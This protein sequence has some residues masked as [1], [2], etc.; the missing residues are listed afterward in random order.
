MTI[1]VLRHCES[2]FNVDPASTQRDCPL[3][4]AGELHAATLRGHYELV[5]V[6]PLR[7]ARQTLELSDITYGAVETCA[8]AREHKT[9]P[10]DC[11]DGEAFGNESEPEV[12]A[13]AARLKLFLAEAVARHGNVL[14]IAHADIVWYLTASRE[15]DGDTYGVWLDP[16]E[17]RRLDP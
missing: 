11:V 2:V 1:T 9:G 6:S 7:R 13:R 10:C 3:S 15:G 16:G 12:I 17:M 14:L 4:P 8:L 5:L